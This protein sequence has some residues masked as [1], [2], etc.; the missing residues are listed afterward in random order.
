MQVNS[1]G[2]NILVCISFLQNIFF[3]KIF[4]FIHEGH[5]QREA[6][7]E[8]EAGFSQGPDAGLDSGPQDYDLS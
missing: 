8:G 7:T 2:I 6:E 3:L 1:D 4:L 5:T